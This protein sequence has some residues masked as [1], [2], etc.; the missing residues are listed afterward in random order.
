MITNEFFPLRSYCKKHEPQRKIRIVC[1]RNNCTV[2]LST[3]G[4][5]CY[6]NN[7]LIQCGHC[8]QLAHV[9]CM[10]K[11][12]KSAGLTHFKCTNC[13]CSQLGETTPEK[14]KCK[15]DFVRKCQLQVIATPSPMLHFLL[16]KF[17][18]L[19]FS[20]TN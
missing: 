19:I 17:L 11:Y 4:L 5:D 15:Q 10:K 13:N 2:C 3:I 9:S 12:A 7:S 6:R 1:Q 8:E 14:T 18:S 20:V 16:T